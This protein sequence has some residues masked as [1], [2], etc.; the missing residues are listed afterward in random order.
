MRDPLPASIA[1]AGISVADIA[2][3]MYAFAG[4]L[5]AL[6]KRARTG[7][8]SEVN[9]SL[10]DALAEWM[11]NPAY[12]TMYGGEEPERIGAHHAT[13]APYGAFTTADESTIVLSVQNQAEWMRFC[14]G[15]LGRADL[16]SDPRFATNPDRCRHRDE[17]NEIVQERVR[18]LSAAEAIAALEDVGVAVSVVRTMADFADHPVLVSRRRWSEIDS[19]GGRIKALLPPVDLAGS[20]PRMD[21][22]PELG[23]HTAAVLEEMG[24]DSSEIAEM[25]RSGAV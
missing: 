24:Y 22:V 20:T 12:Y 11:G 13:I 19:P 15:F 21:P 5:A 3:G 25:R 14:P 6:V 17:L 16:A 4:V 9:V 18:A 10:F 8:G 7:L 23:A 1:R 2:A